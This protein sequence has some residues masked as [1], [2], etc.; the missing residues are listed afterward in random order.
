MRALALALLLACRPTASVERTMPVAN[1]QS[2]RSVA[3]RVHSST[4]ASQGVA[5]MME[6]S[7][8]QKLRQACG[9]EAVGPAGTSPADV[10]LDLNITNKSRGAGWKD[11]E[12]VIDTL[13]VLSDGVDGELQRHPAVADLQHFADPSYVGVGEA[14]V[15]GGRAHAGGEAEPVLPRAQHR[16]R[17]AGPGGEHPDA[18]SLV[19]HVCSVH[20]ACLHRCLPTAVPKPLP[21]VLK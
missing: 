6:Q 4:F 1:L 2:Y 16:R 11:N 19:H 18:E 17:D 3:L 5:M 20:H 13:L 10:I 8:V 15:P 12:V 14:A 21:N 7:V 9:F